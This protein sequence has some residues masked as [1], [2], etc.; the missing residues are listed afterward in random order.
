[1]EA[2]SAKAICVSSSKSLGIKKQP[3]STK[4]GSLIYRE[5]IQVSY[6]FGLTPLLFLLL[7]TR[8][9]WPEVEDAAFLISVPSA[10][11]AMKPSCCCSWCIIS[12]S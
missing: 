12:K 4:I 8:P 11:V 5:D 1:M 2:E 10:V 7:L 9:S 6:S 3:K